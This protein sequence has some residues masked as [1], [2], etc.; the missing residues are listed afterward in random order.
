M[1]GTLLAKRLP[2]PRL[3]RA[4][5]SA[6]GSCGELA[7]GMLEETLLMVTCPIDLFA[8]ATVEI[9]PGAGLVHGPPDSPKAT[10]AVGLVLERLG[11]DDVNARLHLHSPIPRQKGMASSTADVVAAIGASAAALNEEI[12]ARQVAQLAL[13]IEPSD[14]IML[15]GITL[16]AHRSGRIARSLGH[17]PP[18]R[19]LVLEFADR[20]NTETFNQVDRREVLRSQ[21][22]LFGEAVA[23][24]TAG[25]ERGDG[26]LVGQGATLNTLAYQGVFPNPNLDSV[27]DLARRVGSAGVNVAHSGTVLGML[28]L[29]DP[30]QVTWADHRARQTLSGLKATHLHRLIGGGLMDTRPA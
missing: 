23:L 2:R 22:K 24:I 10:R 15:P 8:T 9:S 16:F 7:Q 27:L 17:A 18:M 11:R 21:S 29:D 28:F 14:G 6:P 25:I 4:S 3:G 13:Q 5:A 1:S 12:P 19:V 30:E 20:V 26:R